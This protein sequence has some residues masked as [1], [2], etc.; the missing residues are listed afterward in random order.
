MGLY[1]RYIMPMLISCACAAGPIMK[2]R[3]KVV[4]GA[5][6]DVLELGMGAGSNLEFYDKTRVQKVFAVEPSAGMRTRAV[7]AAAAVDLP[8][9]I[10]DGVGEDLPF[11]D[12]SFD[13]IV[14]TYTLCTVSDVARTLSEAKRVLRPGGRF[15]FCEHGLAP[16]EDVAVWQ[17][18]IEPIWKPIGGGCHLTRR[19]VDAITAAGFTVEKRDQFYLPRTPR[20]VGW[21]EWG[22]AR[23]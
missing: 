13:C 9:E 15:L 12:H 17:R 4:P 6:G 10:M 22:E 16:D 7:A 20:V 8:V 5:S 21:T 3:A 18:R 23:I 2:Q 14:C 19:A 11:A 1:D